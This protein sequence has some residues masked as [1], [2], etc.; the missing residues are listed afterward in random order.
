MN[1][2]FR[3]DA[4]EIS[5]QNELFVCVDLEVAQQD[6]FYF[7]IHFQVEDR[8]MESFFFQCVV[9][10]IVVERD[11]YWCSGT[12]INDTRGQACNALAAARS[13]PQL[14]ACKCDYFHDEAPNMQDENHLAVKSP[15][16]RG[17]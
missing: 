6:L 14:F 11:I 3:V 7:A 1:L 4:L 15:A 10:S 13:G 8:R 9:Q 2:L 17:F 5:V 12:A 16:T